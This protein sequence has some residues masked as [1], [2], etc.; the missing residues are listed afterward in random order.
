MPWLQTCPIVDRARHDTIIEV[1]RALPGA[2]WLRAPNIRTG[3]PSRDAG[4][5]K[6]RRAERDNLDG[7]VIE[8][9]AYACW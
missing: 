4:Q 3:H 2:R 7:L 6:R 9:I 1:D 8:G 5:E